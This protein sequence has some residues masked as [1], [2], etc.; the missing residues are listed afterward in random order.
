[1]LKTSIPQHL[2]A[3]QLCLSVY[4]SAHI[5]SLQINIDS[6][7]YHQTVLAE[8]REMLAVINH[9]DSR[10]LLMK[11]RLLPCDSTYPLTLSHSQKTINHMVHAT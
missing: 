3:A 6:L 9:T 8:P 5:S 4:Y 11:S 10:S 7:N 2:R 1:M